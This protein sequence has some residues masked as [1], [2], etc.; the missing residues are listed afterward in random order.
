MSNFSE[1]FPILLFIF[2][3]RPPAIETTTREEYGAAV[4]T[5]FSRDGT[6]SFELLVTSGQQGVA[7]GATPLKQGEGNIQSVW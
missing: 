3:V 6:V 7:G 1:M 4:A 5:S 2:E